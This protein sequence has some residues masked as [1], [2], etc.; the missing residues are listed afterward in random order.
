M[1]VAVSQLL[2][3]PVA[4]F[5]ANPEWTRYAFMFPVGIFVATCAQTAG[6][7]GAAI[8]GPFFV[9]GFPL[10][11][12]AYPLHSV[13]AS[14]ATAILSEAFGFSSGEQSHPFYSARLV[15]RDVLTCVGLFCRGLLFTLSLVYTSSCCPHAAVH[16]RHPRTV[17]R[18]IKA[19]HVMGALQRATNLK[20]ATHSRCGRFVLCI[21][22]RSLVFA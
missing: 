8:M 11:G 22:I 16:V 19:V 14:V 12:P 9:L 21:F 20:T 15:L 17:F 3:D 7:G 18:S 5:A 10:L 4:S 13:A 6:I 1:P 2:A